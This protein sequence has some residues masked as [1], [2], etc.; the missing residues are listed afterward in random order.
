MKDQ[1]LAHA[2]E[3]F[4]KEAV[5]L[6]HVVKGKNRYF[7]CKNIAET[8]DEH[9]I[10][11]PDDYLK[12]ETKGEI[13]AVVH[14]H[15]KTS[16]A[17]SPADMVACEASGLPWFIV[18]PNT[19]TWGSYTPNGF[20]LPYVGREFSHGI[21]DCYSLVRD[22]YKREFNLELNDY[23]RRDQWWYKGENMY[24]DNFAKEGFKEI[25]ISEVGYGDLFL[26]QLESPVPNHAAIYLDQGIV[27]HHVQGRLS[28]RDVYGGYYQ[29]V[30]AKVLKHE[31]R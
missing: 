13:T 21:V 1:A 28:S 10:L 7:K 19:E 11:D 12:A 16:P 30:T 17:P 20:E 27:L 5:G 15:P 14:S 31:S 6:V 3:D 24:L 22:F 26:M 29:K 4:P 8:P 2:K 23:N 25:D 18:N 9:F